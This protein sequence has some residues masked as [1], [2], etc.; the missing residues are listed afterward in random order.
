LTR[1][2][3]ATL[4]LGV[5]LAVSLQGGAAAGPQP[6]PAAPRSILPDAIGSGLPTD[7]AV[8]IDF[9]EAMDPAAVL[10]SLDVQPATAFVASWSEDGRVMELRPSEKWRT[11]T[12]Y[13]V[14]VGAHGRAFS[15]TTETA[16]VITDF[17][18]Y[19]VEEEPSERVRASVVDDRS[20]EAA[21]Q[22]EPPTD[23]TRNVSARTSITIGFSA[24][25]HE[26]DTARSFTITPRVRGT[27]RWEGGLLVFEPTERLKPGARYAVSVVGA[28]DMRGNRL[29]GDLSF[30]FTTR[31]GAQ[32]VKV[33]P[34][35]GAR[36][37]TP[38][39]VQIWF[40]Q[41]MD[42]QATRSA[43]T[44]ASASGA[45]VRGTPEWNAAGT[46]LRYT[47]ARRLAAGTKFVLRLNGGRDLDGNRVSGRWTFTTKAPPPRPEP[48]APAE[49]EPAEPL[50][51][52]QP[53]PPPPPPPQSGPSAPADVLQF[54]LWQ[55]NQSRAD[56]G[57]GPLRLDGA[58][59][60]VATAHAWDMV[61]YGYFSHTGR[62]GSSPQ[63][64]IAR[65]GI[66][67]SR[68]SE[69]ICYYSGIGVRATL[70]WCHRVFMAE[71]YPGHF[72]HIANILSPNFS[73]VGI[74]IAERG[75][76]VKIVWD[77][78]G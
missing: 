56:Y 22:P 24:P 58:L 49:P 69:N 76:Q 74:G 65:A 52:S 51:A 57:F 1:V 34:S 37:V 71:P 67:F 18:V 17:Q 12:R 14:R 28:H 59:T 26:A 48:V 39:Q 19:Y 66:G 23:T 31:R 10:D 5:V 73:R 20:E 4:S 38:D 3:L 75:G 63:Q 11:D 13:L 70:E 33:V 41:P 45:D 15:F 42:R 40:S 6:A 72:N 8:R 46:Q 16:P 53:A 62:D 9:G 21:S 35:N 44:V 54:A 61:N 60:Q 36:G 27:L 32:V 7:G 77:F 30:S 55:I 50:V 68:A 2:S 78:A 25:M 64:R 47:F 43:L 29:S